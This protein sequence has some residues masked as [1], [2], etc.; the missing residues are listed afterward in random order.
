MFPVFAN[1]VTLRLFIS[2]SFDIV[3]VVIPVKGAAIFKIFDNCNIPLFTVT[4]PWKNAVPL[5]LKFTTL[6]PNI[7]GI[8]ITTLLVNRASAKYAGDCVKRAPLK[9]VDIP[10]II[11]LL[12]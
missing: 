7:S 6:S 12:A 2:V 11:L 3:F 1:P 9:I 10:I 5:F 4:F 8:P